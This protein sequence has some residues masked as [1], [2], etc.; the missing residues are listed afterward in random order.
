MALV[1][2]ITKRAEIPHEPGEFME[3]KKLSWKQLEHAQEISSDALMAKMKSMGGDLIQAFTKNA[4]EEKAD[5]SKSYDRD[6]ILQKGIVKWSYDAEVSPDN[7]S[8]LDEETAVWAFKEI[9]DMN[10]PRTED[11]AKNV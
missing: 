7:I 1:T 6:Y 10:L 4:Q 8:D 3:F 2:N 9:L 5:P 11:E